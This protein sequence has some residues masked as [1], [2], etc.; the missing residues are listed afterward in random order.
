MAR[1]PVSDIPQVKGQVPNV[2]LPNTAVPSGLGELGA[3]IAEAGARIGAYREKADA[4]RV[5]QQTNELHWAKED[6]QNE[7]TNRKGKQIYDPDPLGE[8]PNEDIKTSVL[9]RYDWI[10]QSKAGELPSEQRE[11]FSRNA[12]RKRME[13]EL[14]IDDHLNHQAGIAYNDYAKNT[15]DTEAANILKNGVNQMGLPEGPMIIQAE[16][17]RIYNAIQ[18]AQFNGKDPAPAVAAVK[19]DTKRLVL[20]SLLAVNSVQAA[21]AYYSDH[22]DELDEKTRLHMETKIRA[23]GDYV[24]ATSQAPVIEAKY[25]APGSDNFD[26]AGATAEAR[27]FAGPNQAL[28]NQL[29]GILTSN[30]N[31][32]KERVNQ[33]GGKLVDDVFRVYLDNNNSFQA[34]EAAAMTPAFRQL[35]NVAPKTAA[36][37][38][39]HLQAWDA[40]KVTATQ[41]AIAPQLEAVNYVNYVTLMADKDRLQDMPLDE[42]VTYLAPDKAGPAYFK[43]LSEMRDNLR[44]D[45]RQRKLGAYKAQ[46]DEIKAYTQLLGISKSEVPSFQ[47]E[48]ENRV[49][50]FQQRK[51]IQ[52][53]S[54]YDERAKIAKE[55]SEKV[56]VL[57][58]PGFIK[59]VISGISGN[60]VFTG[61]SET[62]EPGY[63]AA[64]KLRTGAYGPGA[65]IKPKPGTAP[66]Q[67]KAPGGEPPM[68][69]NFASPTIENP[70]PFER[71]DKEELSYSTDEIARAD[72][73][74]VI[75]NRLQP[76]KIR[77]QNEMEL[78]FKLIDLRRKQQGAK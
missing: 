78:I 21:S 2:N 66:T 43:K 56:T 11:A 76:G 45:D 13:L 32:N 23:V 77:S 49:G 47:V 6:L 63:K 33:Q 14:K 61:P 55:L 51:D 1:I 52:R 39:K 28:F 53:E 22:K 36:E 34:A 25:R 17:R 42:F 65:R 67:P 24:Q 40:A 73:D 75:M 19:A 69:K 12:N 26:L 46:A 41:K 64:V 38:Y 9:K 62:T 8:D 57:T 31:L 72:R 27:A 54:T 35:K 50:E 16:N 60:K 20:E 48:F 74:L 4:A 3:S 58:M 10:A 5:E 29:S 44:S 18:A 7:V 70:N 15:D 37:T 59:S 30:Y 71:P 68:G